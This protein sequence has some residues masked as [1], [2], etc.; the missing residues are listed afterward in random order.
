MDLG[1]I[2]IIGFISVIVGFI[3]LHIDEDVAEF[4]F[5]GLAFLALGAFC[6]IFYALTGLQTIT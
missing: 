6:I 3:I 2:L 4:T 5:L 1:M